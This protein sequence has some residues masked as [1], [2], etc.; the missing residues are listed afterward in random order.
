MIARARRD[1]TLNVTSELVDL[2]VE[3]QILQL[4]SQLGGEE[5][6]VEAYGRSIEEV[7][8]SFRE[9]IR[10]EILLQQYRGRRISSIQI[11]PGEV[12]EWFERIPVSERPL[13]PELVRLA[14]VV[15]VPEGDRVAVRAF[16]ETLRDSIVAGQA[17]I[18]ELSTVTPKTPATPGAT[19]PRTVASTRRCG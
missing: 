18:E 8:T 4:S 13:I 15:K 3:R 16:V 11:T 2:Q 14:H 10:D 7:K 17:T 5:A 12:R 1:T 19:G 6:L 9:D